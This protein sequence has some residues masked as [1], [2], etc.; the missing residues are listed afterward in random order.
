MKK[1]YLFT[2]ALTGV[3]TVGCNDLDT[4]PLGGTVTSDQKQQVI[5]NDPSMAEAGVFGLPMATKNVGF[6]SDQLGLAQLRHDDYG[7]ASLYLG[8]DNRG[9]DMIGPNDGYNWYGGQAGLAD[10]G[11]TYYGN[12]NFWYY[13]YSM[14][15]SANT[16]AAGID[17]GTDVAE[18]QYYRAQAHVFRAYAYFMLANMYQRTY[19]VNPQAPCVPLVTDENM[20]RV[21]VDGTPRATVQEVYDQVIKDCTAALDLL[22]K[23]RQSGVTRPDKRFA[24]EAVALGLRARAYLTMQKYSEAAA[25]A[26]EAINRSGCTPISIAQASVPGFKS[27]SNSN[28]MWGIQ[29]LTSEG[30][31]QGV[32]NFCS[33]MG[34]WMSN[35]YCSVGCARRISK[36]LY[37]LI[38]AT[39]ARRN[40]WVAAD[41]SL[42]STLPASYVAYANSQAGKAGEFKPYTV[43]KFDAA[44]APGGTSG[45]IDIPMMR[46]EEMYYILAEAQGAV[47][48]STGAATLQSFVRQFRDPSYTC[49]ASDKDSFLNEIWVQRRIEFWGEGLSYFD[50]MRF[51]KGIDRRGC[52][53]PPAWVFNISNSDPIMHYQI[54][55]MEVESNPLID[56]KAANEGLTWTAAQP[57]AD[58]E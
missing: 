11:G 57:V 58:T 38:P 32:N 12:L 16:V 8:L 49:S 36:K 41:G 25:D 7:Y 15:Q 26:Q 29:C 1:I 18:L 56:D 50:L 46:V 23:A 19:I 43:L 40:W 10:W 54:P 55:Q 9:I 51:E 45:A 53:F 34:P 5:E 6:V 31:T 28:Y 52:G 33:M 35:G 48:P 39:D 22:G 30:F 2:I 42:P 20:N 4:E 44:D 17:E 47:T 14:I 37:A 27:L 13:N 3:L 21:A 24:D